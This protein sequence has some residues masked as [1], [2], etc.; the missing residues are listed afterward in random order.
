MDARKSMIDAME[1]G[2]KMSG[3]CKDRRKDFRSGSREKDQP[4]QSVFYS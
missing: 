3:G 2:K 1:S 4:I